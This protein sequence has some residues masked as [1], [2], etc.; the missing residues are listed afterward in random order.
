MPV[1]WEPGG[2]PPLRDIYRDLI[3]LRKKHTAFSNEDVFW[4]ENSAP[5]EVVSFL[6]RDTKDEFLVL[7]NFSSR[8]VSG[9]VE[10]PAE[11]EFNPVRISGMP[12]PL[13][14]VLPEFRLNGYGW[15]I[16][17]RSIS[18]PAGEESR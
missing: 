4:V 3:K 18:K 11:Q 7:I 15:F 17:H 13:S 5:E 9:S 10:L 16:Y 12:G 6:R 14:T 8:R 1:F 2:R